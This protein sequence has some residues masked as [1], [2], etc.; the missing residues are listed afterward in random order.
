MKSN[1]ILIS[2]VIPIYKTE[3]Y[4]HECIDSVLSQSYKNVEII[5]VDDG[6][7]DRCPQICDEYAARFNS[8]QVIH[9]KNGGLSDARNFGLRKAT[10]DYIIFL[11][12]DDYW[13]DPVAL[14][15]VVE[16]IT[17]HQQTDIVLFNRVYM[18]GNKATLRKTFDVQCINGKN[19]IDILR[20]LIRNDIL[21]VSACL[22]FVR[23]SLIIDNDIEFEKGRLSED[24]DWS[25]NIFIKCEHIRAI[26]NS[27][28]AYRVRP[29]SITHSVSTKHLYDILHTIT[30][31]ERRLKTINIPT[32][33]KNLYINFIAYMYAM[34]ISLL[35][36]CDNSKDRS[37]MIQSL[38]SFDYLLKNT[39]SKKTQKVA[40]LYRITGMNLT[41]RILSLR[42]LNQC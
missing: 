22:K 25:L 40:T 10:G 42:K 39:L 31:W 12:S 33:E 20:Y 29:G 11:D 14:H 1:N 37:E 38:R 17:T 23:R 35:Y 6:S 8:I 26:D 19:K 16:V 4:L 30:T 41:W 27:F 15:T 24:Y 18:E 28:Y 13:N 32:E 7:P 36:R 5:L 3:A 2:I 21:I 34:L 9:K